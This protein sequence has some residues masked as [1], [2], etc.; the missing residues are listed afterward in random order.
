ML[1]SDYH[2]G[3]R[4]ETREYDACDGVCGQEN[5]KFSWPEFL[6]IPWVGATAPGRVRSARHDTAAG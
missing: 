5:L 4:R 2:A 6:K 3:G 1:A